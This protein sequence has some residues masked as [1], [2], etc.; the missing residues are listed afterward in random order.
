MG[1]LCSSLDSEDIRYKRKICIKCG[2]KFSILKNMTRTHC[3]YHR[4]NNKGY[5][6]DCHSKKTNG[7]CHH[8][9]RNNC[10]EKL[11]S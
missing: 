1:I 10:I 8:V 2:D 3:R 5:C 7:N 6:L 11:F 4:I 9:Y